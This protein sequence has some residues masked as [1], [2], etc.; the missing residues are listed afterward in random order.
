MNVYD[1][2]M[3]PIHGDR[4]TARRPTDQYSTFVKSDMYQW[5]T[6]ENGVA[7]MVVFQSSLLKRNKT[8]KR[9]T[10]EVGVLRFGFIDKI[11]KASEFSQN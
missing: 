10:A 2:S 7:A 5:N 8:E 6:T 1:F 3:R 11:V 9:A 4:R